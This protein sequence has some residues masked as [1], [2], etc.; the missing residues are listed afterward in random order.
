MAFDISLKTETS[1]ESD[2]WT[3]HQTLKV[4]EGPL[5]ENTDFFLYTGWA[6]VG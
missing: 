4:N 3:L 6:K 2:L 1:L 5:K